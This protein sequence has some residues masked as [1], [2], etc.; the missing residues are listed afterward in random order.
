MAKQ[1]HKLTDVKVKAEKR[2]GLHL[3]GGGLYLRITQ[4][5][6]KSWIFRFKQLGRGRDLGLGAYPATSLAD[7]RARAIKARAQLAEGVDPIKTKRTAAQTTGAVTKHV[8]TFAEAAERFIASREGGWRNDKHRQQWRNTLDQYAGPVI[9]KKDVGVIDTDDILRIL[10]PIW[11]V[12][13]E[14]ASRLR[15]RIENVLDW[16]KVRGLRSGENPATW[17]GHLAHLLSARN[18]AR[19]VRHHAALPWREMPRLMTELRGNSSVSAMALQF[20]ILTAVRTSEAIEAEWTEIDLH[21]GI[22]T[23]PKERMKAVRAHRVPLTEPALAVLAMLPRI[24]G[25]PHVFPG[26]RRGRPLSNMAMLELLRGMRP[27]LTV[28]GFRST[29][30]DWAAETTV[31]P[32]ELAEAALAHILGS[33]TERAYQRGDLFEKRRGLMAAWADYCGM[34]SQAA[35]GGARPADR[36][37]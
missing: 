32:R 4:T 36:S 29:F 33:A 20:T 27:G 37:L 12:K 13:A 24:D 1:T 6:T 8:V 15:G 11:Q 21:E 10:E 30:R 26:A 25:G 22:W 7:A 34:A 3:D 23:V 5:G 17:R 19:T 31:F 18:K 16:A 35:G 28:H 9:G 2:P 14:T